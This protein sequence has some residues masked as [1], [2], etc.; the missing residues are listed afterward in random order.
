MS[1][2]SDPRRAW[3]PVTPLVSLIIPTYRRTE[4]LRRCLCA[5]TAQDYAPYEVIVVDDASGD[6]T[7]EMVCHEF[8]AVRL[9]VQPANRGPATARNRGI[10]AA[11]GEIVAFT[12]DDCLL[13]PDFLR[14]LVEGYC[15]HP[16]VVGV[17]GYLDPP[18]ALLAANLWAQYEWHVTHRVYGFGAKPYLGG[19][20]CPAGG[21]N[22]MSYR[23]SELVAAGGFDESFPVPGGEDT[24]LKQRMVARGGTLLYV[25]VRVEHMRPYTL[26]AFWRQYRAHGQGVV[27]FERKTLGRPPTP[28]RVALR[29]GKR[30]LRWGL[31]V[32]TLGPRLATARL[33]AELA[34]VAG[35]CMELRKLRT[36]RMGG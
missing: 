7:A 36:R 26:A 30:L 35:Q 19:L 31:G 16:E 8:P 23:R 28:L 22:S 17:G 2:Q 20:D 29:T 34:D 4:V 25:P 3:D 24:E 11:Q 10:A 21:T 33:I 15:A 12:D 1:T 32:P 5:A 13:P 14:R 9:L 6:G 27:H 18:E